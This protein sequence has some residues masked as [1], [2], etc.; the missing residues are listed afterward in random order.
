MSHEL[1]MNQDVQEKLRQEIDDVRHE[2][3]GEGITY[4]R[5]MQMTYLDLVV[6]EN[7]RKWPPVPLVDREC[8]KPY[9]MEDYAGKKHYLKEGDSVGFPIFA[10]HND[11]ALF[12][13]PEKFDPERFSPERIHEIKPYSYFPFGH[14]PRN[15]IGNRFALME[16]KIILFHFLSTFRIEKSSK[17]V[18]PIQFQHAPINLIPVHDFWLQLRVRQDGVA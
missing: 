15:C 18:D 6:T 5:I 3:N 4:D 1:A 12:P 16:A 14:G 7:L 11:P 2:L 9:V 10:M 8:T 17:T 13:N